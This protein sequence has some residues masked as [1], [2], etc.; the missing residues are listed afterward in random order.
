MIGNNLSVGWS[1]TNRIH[2]SMFS[3]II[4]GEK[5]SNQGTGRFPA[6]ACIGDPEAID[7]G[8]GHRRGGYHPQTLRSRGC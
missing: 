5:E 2:V 7:T 4:L 1:G 3:W 8:R 6:P